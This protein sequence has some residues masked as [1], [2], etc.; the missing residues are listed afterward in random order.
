MSVSFPKAVAFAW[1]VGA[2]VSVSV[3]DDG[4]INQTWLIDTVD[5]RYALRRY[6]KGSRGAIERVHD[7]IAYVADNGL[8][9]V[10]PLITIDGDT[11]VEHDGWFYALFLHAL[12]AQIPRNQLTVHQARP[13]GETLAR[14]H[15]T[16]S[17]VPRRGFPS[18]DAPLDTDRTVQGIDMLLDHIA[19]LSQ[20]LETDLWAEIRLRSR[21]EWLLAHSERTFPDISSFPRQV[22][23]GDFHESNL[24]FEGDAVTA[25]LDWDRVEIAPRAFEIVRTMHISL[26]LDPVLCGPFLSAYRRHKSMENQDLQ[27]IVGWYESMRAHDLWLYQTLYRD[28]NER[29][30]RFVRPG[31]FLPFGTAWSELV[32]DLPV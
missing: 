25:I 24:F 22:T 26:Q 15:H 8:P 6:A 7:L 5:G 9:A 31:P 32:S 1:G 12:G 13:M 19:A 18:R 21:R 16:L 2:P 4:V 27:A 17:D 28:G 29:V 11:L 30:R 23:H 3:P 20:P 14:L 10:S